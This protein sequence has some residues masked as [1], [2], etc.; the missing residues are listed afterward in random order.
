[1]NLGN[2]GFASAVAAF[3]RAV[4]TSDQ[5]AVRSAHEE[6][7]DALHTASQ[8]EARAAG[9]LLADLLDELPHGA[10]AH[11]ALVVGACVERG[12]DAVTCAPPVLANLAGALE[13]AREFA[14][15]W[16]AAEGGELPD[17]AN[18]DPADFF[19]GAGVH[20]TLSW[21]TLDEWIRACLTMLQRESVR[22]G[23]A[24]STRALLTRRHE[25]YAKLSGDWRKDLAYA[26]LVLDDEPVVVLHRETGSGFLVRITGIGDNF[27]LHTLLADV[28]IGGGHLPGEAPSAAAAA[29]CRTVDGR[30][31]TRGSLNLVAADGTWLWHEGTPAD[32]PVVEGS[33]LLVL[34]PPPYLRDWQ[35]GRYFRA[36]PGELVLERTLTKGETA[37]WFAHVAPAKKSGESTGE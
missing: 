7:L 6:L 31:I 11:I 20:A 35:A 26:L 22:R 36:M 25:A 4:R 24:P 16:A 29:V 14:E 28:L 18:I 21:W 5:G 12:A 9:P 32:I 1:M 19:D 17:P 33:R 34:D 2:G 3:G 27:Q 37:R 10:R 30:V 8:A 23:L 13:D 15:Y